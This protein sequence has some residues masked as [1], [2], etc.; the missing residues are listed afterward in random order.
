MT[1]I[2][3]LINKQDNFEIIRDKIAE[4]LVVESANQMELACKDDSVDCPD[5]WKLRV[6]AE[7]SS[8]WEQF[9][10]LEEIPENVEADRSPI[11]NV[12]FN[13]DS[14]DLVSSNSVE[15]RKY[16]GTF[17]ID[18]YGYGLSE[19]NYN[20][21]GHI[22]GDMKA[23]ENAHAASRLVRNI[24]EASIYTY[25]GLPRGIVWRRYFQSRTSFQPQLD[26]RNV[27]HVVAVRLALVVEYSENAPEYEG[28]PLQYVSTELFKA[29][30]GQFI[31]GA[32]YQYPQ[33]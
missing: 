19:D 26:D 24:I 5:Q 22:P 29:E 15:R 9:L 2:Q 7:R 4:I 13:S 6:Y 25:L 31:L 27:Q 30:D 23:A 11:V 12:W 3:S 28:Q 17:N 33:T 21:G 16:Q 8:P 18:V 20:D 32:D 10:D 14:I 1:L